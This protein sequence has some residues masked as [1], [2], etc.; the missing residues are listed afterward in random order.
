MD[1]Y[2]L[3]GSKHQGQ[4]MDRVIL[5][6]STSNPIR[7]MDREGEPVELSEDDLATLKG[8]GAVTRKVA[9]KSDTSDNSGDD[10]GGVQADPSPT[11]TTTET[12]TTPST[13]PAVKQ[14]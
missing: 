4:K 2:K 8:M 13:K 1:K 14:R 5:E 6:G 12:T 10:T 3:I 7:W 9:D 11:G